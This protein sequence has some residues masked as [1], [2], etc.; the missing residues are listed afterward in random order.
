MRVFIGI[1]PDEDSLERLDTQAAPLRRE[2]PGLNWIPA[3]NLHLTLRFLGEMADSAAKLVCDRLKKT[4]PPMAP[5]SVHVHGMGGFPGRSGLRVIWAGLAES[6]QLKR[7]FDWVQERLVEA[8]I[9]RE[10]RPFHAHITLARNR[11]LRNTADL[12]QKLMTAPRR[13]TTFQVN[14]VTVFQSRLLPEGPR[15][16]A[17]EE[18]S[19]DCA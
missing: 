6:S 5:F 14:T 8:G 18:V 17:L 3:Q 19:L 15:Y 2:F 4:P 9:P 7:L 10:T 12:E 16:S 11:R 13:I 1:K